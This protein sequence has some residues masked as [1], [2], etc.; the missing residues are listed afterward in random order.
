MSVSQ[1]KSLL[2]KSG[3]AK[4]VGI[5]L[6]AVFAGSLF[7]GQCNKQN[8]A[9][10]QQQG[11]AL[12]TVGDAKITLAE[13]EQQKDE[14]LRQQAQFTEGAFAPESELGAWSQALAGAVDRALRGVLYR[15]NAI[16]VSDDEIRKA[17]NEAFDMQLMMLRQQLVVQKK[18]TANATEEQVA[19]A[20]KEQTGSE[21]AELRKSML[22]RVDADMK[23]PQKRAAL[24]DGVS[25]QKLIEKLGGTPAPSDEELKRSFDEFSVLTINFGMAKGPSDDVTARAQRVREEIASGKVTF[26]K[27]FAAHS[28]LPAAEKAKG[29]KPI[30]LPRSFVESSAMLKGL[31]ELKPGQVSEVIAQPGGPT[32]YKLVKIVP[33]VPADFDK[34]KADLQKSYI[35]AR[36]RAAYDEA[37]SKLRADEKQLSFKSQGAKLVYEFFRWQ[38]DPESQSGGPAGR[39]E[40]IKQFVAEA[41]KATTEDPLMQGPAT[42]L[43]YVAFEQMYRDAKEADKKEMAE[44]RLEVLT[45]LLEVTENIDVRLTLVEMLVARKDPAA[46]EQ[47]LMA[48]E[49][50][51]GT[52]PQSQSRY[53][54]IAAWLGKVK[55]Q[56]L[57]TPDQIA[58]IEQAQQRWIADKREH[59]QAEAQAKADAERERKEMEA[60]DAKERAEFE[61]EQKAKADAAK[62][63]AKK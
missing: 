48:A 31:L 1:V 34:R 36:G 5:G 26:E 16:Q 52:G 44:Q 13:V 56:K 11:V 7:T 25:E 41:G 27:A 8:P 35:A 58:K 60:A 28:T 37:L 38:M 24:A 15:Q 17:A 45:R 63:P 33:K 51:T 53:G 62:T 6:A 20:V 19:K 42:L 23:D 3:C 55:D 46:G 4:I 14:I 2:E 29:P 57:A 12:A 54:K 49:N 22:D 47:L 40:R 50:N 21:P 59:D 30:D 61:K 43:Q 32:L 18:L 10:V 39:F 9:A